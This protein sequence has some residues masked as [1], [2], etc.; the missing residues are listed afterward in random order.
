MTPRL[1]TTHDVARLIQV[2]AST[3]SKWIDAGKLIAYRTPGGH[4]RVREQELRSFLELY[5][6]PI[7]A[8]LGRTIEGGSG[9]SD[10]PVRVSH[11][12]AGEKSLRDLRQA[13]EATRYSVTFSGFVN[14][15][16]GLVHA[17][18]SRAEIVLFDVGA[19]GGDVVELCKAL[20]S[21]PAFADSKF[22]LVHEAGQ[23]GALHRL[24]AQAG[25]AA[26]L[27]KPI[28]AAGLVRSA[29]AARASSGTATDG[30]QA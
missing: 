18:A 21:S 10:L 14:P 24:G 6:M 13:F 1:Y 19:K 11:F 5:K 8:E 28:D 4:R 3:V 16:V 22:V 9:D 26:V 7:P 29:L 20:R 12:A 2:D 25:A 15:L 30:Q 23:R 27:R 17:T